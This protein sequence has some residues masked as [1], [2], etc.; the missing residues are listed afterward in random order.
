M[1]RVTFINND[2]AG[3]ADAVEV[4]PGTTTLQLFVDKLGSSAEAK[5][6]LIR[7]NRNP[8]ASTYVLQDGDTLTCTPTKID[9]A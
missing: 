5:N 7:V 4:E 2:G 9:G 3:F 6:Y 1:I 8:S